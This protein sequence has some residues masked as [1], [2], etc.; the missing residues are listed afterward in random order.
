MYIGDNYFADV[1]G[2]R[3]AGIHPV[4]LDIG[5]IIHQPGCPSLKSLT[6]LPGILKHAI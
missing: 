2:A 5:G 6:E 3:N 4:L 1:I